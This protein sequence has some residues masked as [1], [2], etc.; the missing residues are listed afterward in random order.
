MENYNICKFIS[1]KD[2]GQL[3]ATNFVF[4]T[5]APECNFLSTNVLYLVESGGGILYSGTKKK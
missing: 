1:P 4:E 2:R 5:S 3:I